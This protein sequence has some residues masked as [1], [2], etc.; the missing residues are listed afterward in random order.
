MRNTLLLVVIG[1][2]A[3]AVLAAAT[4]LQPT[5]LQ[6][7]LQSTQLQPLNVKTGLWHMTKAVMWTGLPPQMA[8]LMKGQTTSY[9]SC[10]TPKD[11]NSNPWAN[12]SGDACTWTV[13]NS[14]ST[15]MELQ[16]TSC[17]FGNSGMTG[18]VQG[19]IHIIDSQNGTGSMMVT[20]SGN[21]QA[22]HGLATYTGQ[23]VSATCPAP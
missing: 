15:D 13:L 18:E 19:T 23:W 17:N 4:Q 16:G 10:I 14:T 8:A 11:L 7:K 3:S 9:N 6:P 21:G 1:S 12:G 20:V 22:M 2:A 5:Q